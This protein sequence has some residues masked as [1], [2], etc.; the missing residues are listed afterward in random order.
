M[1]AVASAYVLTASYTQLLQSIE[2]ANLFKQA[3]RDGLTQLY[4]VRH[5][6]LLFE[7]E[8]RN[9][10]TL[11]FRTLS[12]IMCDIDNFK[13]V[14]D[15]Y[16]HQAGDTILR[17]IAATIQSKC[18]H[19]DV[20]GRY[21]GEEFII[22]LSG[23]NALDAAALADKIRIAVSEKKFKFGDA[24]YSTTISLGVAE[25]YKEKVKSE[26]VERADK[27]LYESKHT[28]KNKVSVSPIEIT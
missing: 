5:F 1:L 13:R 18:R 20:A 11:K 24:V 3:T 7:A 6:N 2:R 15:T 10:S 4:N 23:A 22:M 17:E 9:E 8:F 25:Y 27:A 14:N 16:G 12:I 19:M 21:G 28:G 26:L